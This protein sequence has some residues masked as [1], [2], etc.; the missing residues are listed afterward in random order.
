M[1]EKVRREGL[2]RKIL[3][4]PAVAEDDGNECQVV[5]RLLKATDATQLEVLLKTLPPSNQEG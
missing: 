5:N 1:P 3:S 4:H 2:E